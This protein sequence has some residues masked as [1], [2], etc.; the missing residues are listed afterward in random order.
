MAL[1]DGRREALRSCMVLAGLVLIAKTT[2]VIPETS[3]WAFGWEA[4]VALGTIGLALA[5]TV[6]AW[7]TRRVAQATQAEIS[8]SWRPVLTLVDSTWEDRRPWTP[9]PGVTYLPG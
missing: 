2:V 1:G 4:L 5:T 9:E 6:L 3:A 8:A 7:S